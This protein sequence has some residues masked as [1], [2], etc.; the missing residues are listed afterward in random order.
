MKR[1]NFKD[2]NLFFCA[3]ILNDPNLSA[4]DKLLLALIATYDNEKK[5]GCIA[6]NAK[7]H[8]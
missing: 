4:L 6:C 3:A 8:S 2:Y 5:G 1:I 7:V